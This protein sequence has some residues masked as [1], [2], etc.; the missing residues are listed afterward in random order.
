MSGD[1][2]LERPNIERPIFRNFEYLNIEKRVIHFFIFEFIFL[3]QLFEN[4]KYT[5]IYQIGHF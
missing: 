3:F 4:S 1:R 2:H 5:I